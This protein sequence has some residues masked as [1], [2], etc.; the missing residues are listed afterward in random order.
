MVRLLH[1]SDLHLGAESY[2]RFDPDT[3]LSSRMGDFLSALD[4]VADYA[5]D[6][7]IH[8]VLF[9][10]DAYKTCD[11]SPTYQREFARRV[12][13]LARSGIPIVLLAGNHDVP[14]ARG[15][16]NAI[17]IFDT[18]AVENVYVASKP[19]TIRLETKGGAIQ[20]VSLPWLGRSLLTALDEHKNKT[21][22]EIRETI[23]E[24]AE[25]IVM[26]EV[27]HLDPAL[28]TVFMAHGSVFGAAYSSER[29]TMLGEDLVLP[30]SLYTHSAFDYVALG[31]I[32]KHQVLNECP[33]VVYSGSVERIDF[34]EEKEEKGFVVA[35]VSKGLA[36][37]RF[38]PTSARKF[39]TLRV[40][41]MSDNPMDDIAGCGGDE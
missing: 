32:H 38:I 3:G 10:G 34:G 9:A 37:Y 21:I 39:M 27:E 17:S 13:R 6:N 35:E 18:L 41:A 12:A 20:I 25:N 15:R 2:G 30:S 24:K 40:E 31:H 28:P 5:L 26:G 33:P 8:L 16:A 14:N 11:P 23:L 36:E 22:E 19:G 29:K 1:F 4:R 7:D